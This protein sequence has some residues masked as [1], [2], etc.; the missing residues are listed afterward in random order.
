MNSKGNSYITCIH[1]RVFRLK[2]QKIL[3]MFLQR[4]LGRGVNVYALQNGLLILASLSYS[5]LASEQH[6]TNLKT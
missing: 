2:Y 6:V 1:A 5:E 4:V 3:Q